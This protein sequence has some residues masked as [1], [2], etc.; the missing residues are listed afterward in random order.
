VRRRRQIPYGRQE[1]ADRDNEHAAKADG[2]ALLKVAKV[3]LGDKIGAADGFGQGGCCAAG[4][5]CCEAAG[6]ELVGKLQGIKA[7]R[8][9][10]AASSEAGLGILSSHGGGGDKGGQ[11]GDIA[12]AL[13]LAKEV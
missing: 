2:Q 12:L 1:D 11:S 10:S 8:G 5:F 6:L 7:N 4:L 9:H 3:C 13:K